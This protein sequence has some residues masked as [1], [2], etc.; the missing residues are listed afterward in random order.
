MLNCGGRLDLQEKLEETENERLKILLLD[1]QRPLHHNNLDKEYKRII[2]VD[3][4]TI[5]MKNCPSTAD[6]MLLEDEMEEE[7]NGNDE[8][9]D[10]FFDE[11]NKN[12]AQ[13]VM[14]INGAK[15]E[16]GDAGMED[17]K[18][19]KQ[20]EEA[21]PVEKEE[22]MEEIKETK[23]V[24][25]QQEDDDEIDMGKKRAKR[26]AEEKKNRKRVQNDIRKKIERYYD[27]NYFGDSIA[28]IVYKLCQQL[29]KEDT[30]LLWYWIL[31][32]TD[33]FVSHKVSQKM[34]ETNTK[35]L[36]SEV[37]RMNVHGKSSKSTFF[38]QGNKKRRAKGI[39]REKC[40][41]LFLLDHWNLHDSLLNSGSS[42]PK[43]KTWN[44]NGKF[45]LQQMIARMGIPLNEA[46]E[47]YMHLNP[48]HKNDIVNRMQYVYGDENQNDIS[49]STFIR[50]ID[51][52]HQYSSL[53]ICEVINF[54]LNCPYNFKE[55]VLKLNE[56][57][58]RQSLSEGKLVSLNLEDNFYCIFTDIL[59]M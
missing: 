41:N 58:D 9:L 45:K 24:N 13:N 5:D 38:S 7:E 19:E 26:K 11:V 22:Q 44:D 25:N 32:E 1:S 48:K 14:N 46:Q 54:I 27:Q 50:I 30:S 36:E 16:N 43:L 18:E 59:N 34:Y 15:K 51:S 47:K 35:H 29:N 4:K 37:I 17:I 55:K 49:I 20:Q 2:L 52:K 57:S 28:R 56:N 40:L 39:Y 8:D 53:D 10:K 6:L 12:A 33:S 21:E 23:E 42:I 31:G 3:D